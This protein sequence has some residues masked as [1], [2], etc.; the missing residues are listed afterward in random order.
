M[1]ETTT[2]SITRVL[3]GVATLSLVLTLAPGAAAADE[4]LAPLVGTTGADAIDQRYIVVLEDDVSADAIPGVSTV[5]SSAGGTVRLT[6]RAALQ[7][8]AASLPP[9]ALAAVR[10]DPRV[11]YVEA[12]AWMTISVDAPRG[13]LVSRLA[14]LAPH[15]AEARPIWNLDR[16]D[17]RA[18]PL[19]DTYAPPA[20]GA[21]VTAYVIDTGIWFTHPEF[22]DRATSGYDF[23]DDDPNA[24]DCNGHGTHVAGTIV[25]EKY[26]VANATQAVALR[27]LGCDGRGPTSQ[28][29]AGVD[30]VTAN[31]ERPAVANMSLGGRPS[32]ALDRAVTRSIKSGVLYAIAAGNESQDACKRSPARTKAALT[33]GATDKRDEQ[34]NHSNFGRCLDLYAPGVLIRSAWPADTGITNTISGTSM[35]S[36]HVAG[37]AAIYLAQ[38]PDA[39]AQTVREAVLDAATEGE[40]TG[41]GPESPNRLVFANLG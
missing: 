20:R 5:A 39:S 9:A 32:R 37:T 3:A 11:A 24:R 40:L 26:G 8:F 15:P 29:I 7:G 22:E 13:G 19:D 12:D 31:A 2:S 23:V 21:G 41:L 18:L 30:W 38:H 28:V 16:I 36:P 4:N 27:V 25:G 34:W 17:Q 33:V 35:A 6:Y 10:A 14:A 1:S